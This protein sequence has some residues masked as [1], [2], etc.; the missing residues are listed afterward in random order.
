M[1]SIDLW[2]PAVASQPREGTLHGLRLMLT[3]MGGGRTA[4]GHGFPGKQQVAP[5]GRAGRRRVCKESR[6]TSPVPKTGTR[7]I[8]GHGLFSRESVA[9]AITPGCRTR[10]SAV[11]ANISIRKPAAMPIVCKREECSTSSRTA[12]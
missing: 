10:R 8:L 2:D 6:E 5:T 3:R 4:I 9:I 1:N 7:G 11:I 12:E